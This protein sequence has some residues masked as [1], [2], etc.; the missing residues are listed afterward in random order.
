MSHIGPRLGCK[1]VKGRWSQIRG[2]KYLLFYRDP[3]MRAIGIWYMVR[4][5]RKFS[6]RKL[7]INKTLHNADERSSKCVK[8]ISGISDIYTTDIAHNKSTSLQNNLFLLLSLQANFYLLF[9][10]FKYS[11]CNLRAY[12]FSSLY[13]FSKAYWYKTPVQS[14]ET[15]FRS[16]NILWIYFKTYI[17]PLYY[18]FI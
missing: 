17:L 16:A 5:D 2:K 8:H 6:G 12:F 9:H 18:Y 3:V 15:K 7:E 14:I 13:L 4:L 11:F 1:I 10:R